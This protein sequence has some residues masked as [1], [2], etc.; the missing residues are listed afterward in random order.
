M[1]SSKGGLLMIKLIL[2]TLLLPLPSCLGISPVSYSYEFH[3]LEQNSR[4]KR[5]GISFDFTDSDEMD[6]K[7][8]ADSA[9]ADAR[10]GDDASKKAVDDAAWE[11]ESLLADA[12]ATI[13]S[14]QID[15]SD[16]AIPSKDG[17]GA[18]MVVEPPVINTTEIHLASSN[19]LR[20]VSNAVSRDDA[21]SAIAYATGYSNNVTATVV[22]L[23]GDDAIALATN[24]SSADALALTRD[25]GGNALS[26]ATTDGEHGTKSG[27]FS[28]GNGTA[29]SAAESTGAGEAKSDAMA[30][31]NNAT[32]SASAKEGGA[33]SNAIA[34]QEGH[35]LSQT[36]TTNGG[37]GKASA[38]TTGGGDARSG[39]LAVGG[40]NATAISK[41]ADGKSVAETVA[42]DGGASY[43]ASWAKKNGSSS[44][45]AVTFG[46]GGSQAEALASGR[47][48]SVAKAY[49]MN[50]EDDYEESEE[51]ID[52][53]MLLASFGF[54][55]EEDFM[56]DPF[57]HTG[58]SKDG[59]AL[60]LIEDFYTRVLGG[61]SESQMKEFLGDNGISEEIQLSADSDEFL[62]GRNSVVNKEKSKEAMHSKETV[63]KVEETLQ[64]TL[65][66]DRHELKSRA[67]LKQMVGDQDHPTGSTWWTPWHEL[68]D[69]DDEDSS[70]TSGTDYADSSETTWT[71]LYS[72]ALKKYAAVASL[73]TQVLVPNIEDGTEVGME[74]QSGRSIVGNIE[75]A[76]GLTSAEPVA[77]GI[78]EANFSIQNSIAD[79]DEIL[80]MNN[81]AVITITVPVPVPEVVTEGTGG[82][83]MD[84]LG[85]LFDKNSTSLNHDDGLDADS[86]GSSATTAT[87]MKKKGLGNEESPNITKL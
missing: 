54:R 67:R 55:D 23:T 14:N 12:D 65:N 27:A 73:A 72:D 53:D 47:G 82:I 24:G 84:I 38:L 80:G 79:I 18:P 50:A 42:K 43:S 52:M 62:E 36:S 31:E 26:G 21:N 70:E 45:N 22:S 15:S 10:A 40:G 9:Y 61:K 8:I 63:K 41:S 7:E 2:V 44:A 71:Q 49:Q 60:D 1:E 59:K 86:E 69:G 51:G 29:T 19:T 4:S 30:K 64:L 66:T 32:S 48:S 76:K 3:N 75:L 39:A 68:K 37:S 81:S 85:K 46:G 77:A 87:S 34:H 35:A 17:G 56:N 11:A 83:Q 28:L 33:I 78:N 25:G 5:S 6:L 20:Q 13:A 16:T 58:E 57:F 74:G